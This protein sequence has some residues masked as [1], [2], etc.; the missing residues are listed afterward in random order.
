MWDN[1]KCYILNVVH[2]Y[3]LQL[4]TSGYRCWA[5]SPLFLFIFQRSL[6]LFSNNI[7]F[8]LVY[9][10]FLNPFMDFNSVLKFI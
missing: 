9:V 6:F 4:F 7:I 1:F 5:I 10:V 8:T 3:A 2:A